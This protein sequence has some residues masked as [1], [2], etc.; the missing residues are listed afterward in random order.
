M[1][2]H[3]PKS[4]PRCE[5][6]FECKPGNITECQCFGLSFTEEEKD[7]IRDVSSDCLCRN[8]L[9]ALKQEYRYEATRQRLVRMQ[10]IMRGK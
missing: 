5:Q 10:E 2:T 1:A 3:E 9:Q 8:C 7:Y 4:C 6:P